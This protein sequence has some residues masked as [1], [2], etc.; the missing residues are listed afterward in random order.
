MGAFRKKLQGIFS[1]RSHLI[2]C[3]DLMQLPQPN[4]LRQFNLYKVEHDT[5]LIDG[6]Y[7]VQMQQNIISHNPGLVETFVLKDKSETIG[8]MSVMYKGGNELEY[9]IRN[10]DAFVYN[11]LIRPEFRGNGYAG[12]MFILLSEYLKKKDIDKPELFI[13]T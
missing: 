11:V 7:S 6:T 3:L 1:I 12:V 10:I 13:E 5:E 4:T 8:I 9:K 2:M